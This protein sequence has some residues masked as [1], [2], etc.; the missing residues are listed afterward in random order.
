MTSHRPIKIAPGF[1]A[2]QWQGLHLDPGT[3]GTTDWEKALAMF[4]A[5]MRR[6]FFEP[7]E[8]LIGLDDARS[9]KTFGFAILAIDCLVIE[10]LQGFRDGIV[11]HNGKSKKLFKDFLL[12]WDAFTNCLQPQANAGELAER[13][14]LDCRCALLHSGATDGALRVGVS[15]PAFRFKDSHVQAIN[16]TSFHRALA[17]EFEGYLLALRNADA[18]ELREHFK[19]KMDAICSS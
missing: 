14:Y 6:R 16:R 4:E 1:S 5:R 7:A 11:N 18:K 12:R 17:K 2:K 19:K 9:D 8:A 15:G 10:T 13:V 3:P